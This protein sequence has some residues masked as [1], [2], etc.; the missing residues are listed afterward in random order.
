M[1][2]PKQTWREK[3]LAKEEGCNSGDDSGKEASKLTLARGEDN[4]E[5]GDGKPELGNCD[6]ESGTCLP[7]LGNRNPNLGNSKPGKENDR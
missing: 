4:P 5:L 7:E 1:T 6:T 2:N 3:W